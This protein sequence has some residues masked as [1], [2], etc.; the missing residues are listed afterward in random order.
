MAHLRA[1]QGEQSEQEIDSVVELALTAERPELA[2]LSL[3]V[4]GAVAASRGDFARVLVYAERALAVGHHGRH[5]ETQALA[6]KAYAL[7]RLERHD[8]AIEVA[9]AAAPV[10]GVGRRGETGPRLVRPWIDLPRGGAVGGGQACACRRRSTRAGALPRATARLRLAEATLHTGDPDA[11]ERELQRVPFG[12]ACHP[13]S[14]RHSC[15]D[16]SGSRA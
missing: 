6:A 16:S 5:L 3:S 1:G 4:T 9:E 13:T 14:R 15:R 7:S 11:A 2:Q 12:P 8:E 10:A